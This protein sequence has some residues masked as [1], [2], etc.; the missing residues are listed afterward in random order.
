[1]WNA[2]EFDHEYDQYPTWKKPDEITY[3][4]WADFRFRP[5]KAS[6]GQ[7]NHQSTLET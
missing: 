4:S 5:Y 3:A 2:P 1:M 6:I 7:S